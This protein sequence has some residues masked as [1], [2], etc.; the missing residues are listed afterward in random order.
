[1]SR[2]VDS[3]V[4]TA[5][6]NEDNFYTNYKEFTDYSKSALHMLKRRDL[7]QHSVEVASDLLEK[8]KRQRANE[9]RGI[10]SGGLIGMFSGKTSMERK[11]ELT[12]AIKLCHEDLQVKVNW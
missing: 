6:Y 5:Q 2:V 3:L 8:K 12:E 11:R 7:S 1:M 10:R 4:T 9:D